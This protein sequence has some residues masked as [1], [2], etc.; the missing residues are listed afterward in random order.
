MPGTAWNSGAARTEQSMFALLTALAGS[1]AVAL[2]PALL[3]PAPTVRSPHPSMMQR[4][5]ELSPGCAPLGIVTAGLDEDELEA[6]TETIESVWQG[7][8]GKISHVPIAMLADGDLRLRLRDVLATISLR[9]SILPDKPASPRVPVVIFS[10][11]STVQT[12][13]AV[14]AVRGLRLRAGP[15]EQH[16]LALAVAVPNSLG[17]PFHVLLEELERTQMATRTRSGN[18]ALASASPSNA[19]PPPPAATQRARWID[20]VSVVVES[21]A[22]YAA[23]S[24]AAASRAAASR[25][26]PPVMTDWPPW[27][28]RKDE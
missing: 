23:A 18:A 24:Q 25:T 21:M 26:T 2:I 4:H 17:K 12:S 1:P 8:D 10:G 15:D 20:A 16:G 19:T 3:G 22:R 27:L 9:D 6:L 5:N 28:S 11:F 7:P 14:R 13:L